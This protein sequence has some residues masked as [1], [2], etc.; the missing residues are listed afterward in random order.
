[1]RH[2]AGTPAPPTTATTAG[3][4][5]KATPTPT[6]PKIVL[7]SIGPNLLANPRFA[8][9]GS[10]WTAYHNAQPMTVTYTPSDASAS[11]ALTN[12]ANSVQELYQSLKTKAGA[13]LVARGTIQIAGAA[14]PTQASVNILFVDS[15]NRATS[16][17]SINLQEGT[18]S[19]PFAVAF[20]PIGEAKQFVIAVITG[21]SSNDKTVVTFKHLQVT[22]QKLP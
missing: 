12:A 1:M 3:I 15:S 5:K 6:P 8:S 13:P 22:R 9:H 17:F 4:A 7:T 16:V 20:T 10:G 14:L 18:G 19:F 21:P 2:I 11:I